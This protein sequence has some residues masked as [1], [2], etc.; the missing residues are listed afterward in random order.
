[1]ELILRSILVLLIALVPATLRA[2]NPQPAPAT[3][4]DELAHI[5]GLLRSGEWSQAEKSIREAME[6]SLPSFSGSVLAAVVARLSLAEAGLGREAAAVWHWQVA[7][8][9]DWK[10]LPEE[11]LRTFGAAGA[12][13]A[14][15]SLRSPGQSPPGVEVHGASPTVQPPRKIEG[16]LAAFSPTLRLL[17]VPFS[18]R[19]QVIIGADGR[20]R[21]PVI[22]AT[23]LPGIAFEGLEALRGWRFEPA[24]KEGSPV[25]A[26]YQLT[27]NPPAK[28]AL[29]ELVP[30]THPDFAEIDRLLRERRWKEARTKAR[31]V[32]QTELEEVS[33]KQNLGHL[34]ALQALAEAGVGAED[35]AICHWQAA[36]HLEPQLYHADLAPYGSAGE[37]L[38]AHR[39]GTA[40]IDPEIEG[41]APPAPRKLPRLTL[42]AKGT[43]IKGEFRLLGIIDSGGNV[44]QPLVLSS[45]SGEVPKGH[46]I[47]ALESVCFW[48]F[49]PARAGNEPRTAA[50]S[51]DI[52][53]DRTRSRNAIT[54]ELTVGREQRLLAPM[55]GPRSSPGAPPPH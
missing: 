20:P 30:L 45:N 14:G 36:Q 43:P 10:V 28:K 4:A 25:A 50:F 44:R 29:A 27:L 7:Q 49:Q 16:E 40:V 55:S 42:P 2:A 26:F 34:L 48:R 52:S 6:Y 19:V 33:G 41:T 32:W 47:S 5:D 24:R 54:R 23:S 37:L 51:W 15:H 21:D 22:L 12:L 8:G 31:K 1:M 9:L 53:F 18:L 35:A 13:L 17:S 46:E 3:L 39:W 38:A 11:R